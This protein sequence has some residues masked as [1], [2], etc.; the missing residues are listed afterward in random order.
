MYKLISGL[1]VSVTGRQTKSGA[2]VTEC[3]LNVRA[4]YNADKKDF[5]RK[6]TKVFL[7][8]NDNENLAEKGLKRVG[9]CGKEVVMLVQETG[10]EYYFGLSL[11]CGHG[12]TR[13]P[14][15]LKAADEKEYAAFN[16]AY[17]ALKKYKSVPQNFELDLEDPEN[18]SDLYKELHEMKAKNIAIGNVLK[19]LPNLFFGEKYGIIGPVASGPKDFTVN[20]KNGIELEVR[21]W[22]PKNNP[23]EYVK[24]TIWDENLMAVVKRTKTKPNDWIVLPT[25][26]ERNSYGGKRQFVAQGFYKIWNQGD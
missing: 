20:G 11:P 5:E 2:A 18:L 22:T 7:Y 6:E 1:L 10:K 21:L 9:L 12:I 16:D 23:P 4:G 24:I 26:F 3:L 19:T 8:N 15:E 17:E 25:C 13:C 14:A